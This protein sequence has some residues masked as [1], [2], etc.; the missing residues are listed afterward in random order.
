MSSYVTP[1]WCITGSDYLEGA[2]SLPSIAA[3]LA[4]A[5]AELREDGEFPGRA[6]VTFG[7]GDGRWLDIRVEGLSPA[8]DPDRVETMAA[9]R[10]LFE[11]SSHANLVDISARRPALFLPRILAVDEAGL[12]YAGVLGAAMGDVHPVA[13]PEAGPSGGRRLRGK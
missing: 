1:A 10:T 13:V 7:V 9:L 8:C 6:K 12:P 4:D 5:V 11:L 2:P 3:L